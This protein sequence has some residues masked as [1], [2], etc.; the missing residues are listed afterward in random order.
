MRPG[1]SR[2]RKRTC[3]RRNPLQDVKSC[4]TL[5]LLIIQYMGVA[6]V[7]VVCIPIEGVRIPMSYNETILE[8]RKTIFKRYTK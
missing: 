3:L 5:W 1:S 7:G 2:I 8:K 6:E 4:S